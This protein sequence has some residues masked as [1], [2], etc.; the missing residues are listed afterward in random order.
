MGGIKHLPAPRHIR[1]SASKGGHVSAEGFQGHA[2]TSAEGTEPPRP[3]PRCWDD[4][5]GRE[6][7]LEPAPWV[8][9]LYSTCFWWLFC[10][11]M[12]AYLVIQRLP[13]QRYSGQATGFFCPSSLPEG[14]VGEATS[15]L[16]SVA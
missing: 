11:V 13:G 3:T 4:I 10:Y 12:D 15:N 8:Q 5:T 2:M 9:L 16:T 1:A 14:K 6:G 7:H